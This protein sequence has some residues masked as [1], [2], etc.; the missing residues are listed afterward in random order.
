LP[1]TLELDETRAR[2]LQLTTDDAALARIA[3]F[4]TE[5]LESLA[6]RP[7]PSV[8]LRLSADQAGEA[9][10]AGTPLLAAGE[11]EV[12]L[13]ELEGELAEVA[14]LVRDAPDRHIAEAARAVASHPGT[15]QPLLSAALRGDSAAIERGAHTLNAPAE[16]LQPLLE[17]AIQP[18]L[19]VAAEQGVLLTD[20]DVWQ[21]GFCVVCGAWPVYGEL[22]GAQK[23]RHLRCGRC[24]AGWVWAVLL[25]P[26]C[27]NDDHRSLGSLH[28]AEEHEYRRIDTC[29]ECR[30]YLKA[31]A[32]FT[33]VP[34]PQLAAEDVA[35]VHL[36]LSARERGYTRPGRIPE[37]ATAGVPRGLRQSG[38]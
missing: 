6:A 32:S 35:T 25:C 23:E 38:A 16:T 17:L 26:Y 9:L 37:P 12:D 10:R 20:F 14:R 15:F 36:D 4:H 31:I 1:T 5:R 27:G 18:A 30:G 22:V 24:G 33:R 13:V 29:E 2:W 3:R 19:W 8:G 34:A 7:A 11:V 21:R 28:G